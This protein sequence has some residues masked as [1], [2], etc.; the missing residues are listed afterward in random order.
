MS[1]PADKL[2]KDLS[3]LKADWVARVARDPA[4]PPQATLLSGY[5]ADSS[6]D[7]H[8][9]LYLDAELSSYVDIPVDDLLHG[10]RLPADQSP[11]GEAVVWVRRSAKLVQG[12]DVQRASS[13]FEGPITRE[14]YSTAAAGT[15]G[16]PVSIP[17][18]G[19]LQTVPPQCPFPTIGPSCPTATPCGPWT[20]PPIC[21]PLTLPPQCFHTLLPQCPPLTIPPRCPPLTPACPRTPVRPCV[22]HTLIG[23]GCNIKSVLTVCPT[24]PALCTVHTVL[25]CP[26]RTAICP[27]TP[28]CPNS[29]FAC[30]SQ[31]AVCVTPNCP[32]QTAICTAVC[33]SAVDACP[34]A[35]GGCDTFNTI[36][37]PGTTVINPG[38]FNGGMFG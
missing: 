11:L 14:Q 37:N 17:A 28:N 10:Q 29:A 18:C 27:V 31:L 7:G 4:Q 23:P 25:N 13:W 15:L 22:T 19:P 24:Q 5:L 38:G 8:A 3:A 30:P 20:L 2:G 36:V 26:P 32:V 1:P 21:P 12:S 35:P 34:S 16:L 6:R 9:R 33:P